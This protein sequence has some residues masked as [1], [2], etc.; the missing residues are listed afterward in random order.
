MSNSA[1]SV[2]AVLS[3]SSVPIMISE[4]PK[5]STICSLLQPSALS[6]TVTGWRRL[7][8]M[9]TPTVSRLST[10]NSSHAPR[11]GITLT[12]CSV[13]SVD[14]SM[15]SSK[16]TLG[17]RLVE[18]A[19]RIDV[20]TRLG[21]GAPALRADQPLERLGLRVKEPR[22]L[23]RLTEL[24]K[25]NS[26]RCSGNGVIGG[27]YCGL[28]AGPCQDASFQHLMRASRCRA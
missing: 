2:P 20:A 1:S 5:R 8:S 26:V 4:K 9:R 23:E 24:G 28:L 19:Q 17:E 22:N 18:A 11:P 12:L 10:S 25:R 3:F 21:V 7:R 6:S 15:V 27:S 16:Y 13:F 14:L